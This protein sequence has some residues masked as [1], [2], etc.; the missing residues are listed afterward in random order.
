MCWLRIPLLKSHLPKS[1]SI[2][3]YSKAKEAGKELE[4]VYVPVADT[5]EVRMKDGKD[6]NKKNQCF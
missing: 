1:L 3:A 4:V 2:Q 5:V 6:L